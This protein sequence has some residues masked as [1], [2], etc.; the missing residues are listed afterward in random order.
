M[1][2]N[3]RNTGIPGQFITVEREDQVVQGGGGKAGLKRSLRGP[4]WIE[5]ERTKAKDDPTTLVVDLTSEIQ[6][7]L[8]NPLTQPGNSYRLCAVVPR[9]G[10]AGKVCSAPTTVP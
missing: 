4:A 1:T 5:M 2:A 10:A 9:L 3:W 7:P 8:Q 6:N